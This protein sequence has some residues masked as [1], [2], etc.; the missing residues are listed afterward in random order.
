MSLEVNRRR[1]ATTAKL[2]HELDKRMEQNELASEVLHNNER[3]WS[4][5]GGPTPDELRN[6]PSPEAAVNNKNAPL[7]NSTTS[8]YS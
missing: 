2:R 6:D 1:T 3:L 4:S 8:D 5:L 7:H